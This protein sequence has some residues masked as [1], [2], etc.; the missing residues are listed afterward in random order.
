MEIVQKVTQS[1]G[2]VSFRD[3]V[4][5]RKPFGLEGSVVNAPG[6]RSSP[7]GMSNPVRCFGKAK[8]VGYIDLEHIRSRHDWIDRWKV[9]TPYANNIATELS[10]DNQNAF[11]VEPGSVCSETFLVLGA[12]TP[13]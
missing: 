2:F 12:G 13:T 8:K 6:F 7:S 4:S 10:D 5:A 9:F 1:E 11:V 3:Q